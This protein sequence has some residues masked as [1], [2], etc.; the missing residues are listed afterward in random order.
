MFNSY[1]HIKNMAAIAVNIEET[2]YGNIR[3]IS[4]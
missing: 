4:N 1:D 3:E 2:N